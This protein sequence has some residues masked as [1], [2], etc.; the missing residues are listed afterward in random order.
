MSG[1]RSGIG[2]MLRASDWFLSGAGIVRH[3][4]GLLPCTMA[5]P[6]HEFTVNNNSEIWVKNDRNMHEVF[7]NMSVLLYLGAS[8]W[9]SPCSTSMSWYRS[10]ISL[11]L[12]ASDWFLSGA[13]IV[14][15]NSSLLPCTKANP[16][17]EFSI[18]NTKWNLSLKWQKNVW[19][20]YQY[21][22]VYLYLRASN[23]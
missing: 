12:R 20:I 3:V 19:T 21:V 18:Y 2:P 8:K 17:H 6:V 14:R 23:W 22:Y 9:W 10:G 1:Y 5:N 7:E 11:M 4:I 16:F 13:G 15:Y